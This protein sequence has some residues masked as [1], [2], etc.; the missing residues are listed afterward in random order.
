MALRHKFRHEDEYLERLLCLTL[1]G[2][3]LQLRIW[4]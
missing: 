1:F 3:R 2:A 4:M